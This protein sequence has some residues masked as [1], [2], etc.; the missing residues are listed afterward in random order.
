[1]TLIISRFTWSVAFAFLNTFNTVKLLIQKKEVTF[2]VGLLN[3]AYSTIFEPMALSKNHIKK[4]FGPELAK[5]VYLE[6]GEAYAIENSTKAD[7]LSL[8][9]TGR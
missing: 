8:L 5:I 9:L 3:D 4:L 6:K 1:M 7:K 2:S